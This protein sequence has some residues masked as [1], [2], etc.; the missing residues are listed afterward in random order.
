MVLEHRHA[1]GRLDRVPTHGSDQ[2]E[3][4]VRPDGRRVLVLRDLAETDDPDAM[5][6]HEPS[7]ELPESGFGRSRP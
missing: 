6:A 3:R 2:F 5:A 1:G 4:R 7:D